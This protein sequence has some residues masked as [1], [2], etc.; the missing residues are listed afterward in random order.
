MHRIL[1]SFLKFWEIS[2]L[3]SF[4]RVRTFW[5]YRFRIMELKSGALCGIVAYAISCA[6]IA[7]LSLVLKHLLMRIK[8][9]YQKL[10]DSYFKFRIGNSSCATKP[11]CH[12]SY[13]APLP[14]V[15]DTYAGSIEFRNTSPHHLTFLI[16]KNLT[17]CLEQ[18]RENVW[19]RRNVVIVEGRHTETI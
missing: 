10:C 3:F 2:E 8:Y 1:D 6:Y 19:M 12:F 18:I 4:F 13:V 11:P 14:H 15:L 7:P 17:N 9:K 16:L 5:N